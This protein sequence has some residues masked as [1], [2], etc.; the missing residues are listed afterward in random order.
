M[1]TP[2]VTSR[3][4]AGVTTVA[5]IGSLCAAYGRPAN[6]SGVTAS[7]PSGRIL[8]RGLLSPRVVSTS[9]GLYV[10]SQVSPLGGFPFS[11]LARVNS[12][13][14]RI[15][16]T[17]RLGAAFDQAV[18][19]GGSLYVGVSTPSSKPGEA[20]L[21]LNARTLEVTRRWSDLGEGGSLA[22]AGGG[23]WVTG[24]DRLLRL[25]L[26]EGN[27][28]AS[29][30]LPGADRSDV[31]SNAAG[32]ILFVGEAD[33]GR[34]ALERRDPETGTLLAS[35]SPMIGVTAPAVA[36]VVG[37]GVW[38]SEATGMM[39]YVQR[40]DAATLTP[41]PGTGTE[42]SNGISASVADGL[43]WVSQIDGGP[44]TNFCGNPSDGVALSPL[45]LPP[46][47]GL[48]A[49]G[50]H[51]IYYVTATTTAGAPLL[52][53]DVHEETIPAACRVG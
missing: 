3:L 10:A 20:L 43:L 4:L 29:V 35:Y 2:V 8:L 6:P 41:E 17:R 47:A 48:Q 5:V 36:E 16:A 25:S 15:A 26:P 14:G 40:F 1:G 45:N 9:A 53:S 22:L 27:V 52:H 42:G 31:A 49:I 21:R 7:S 30:A 50:P 33:E 44:T 37:Q 38:V 11:E 12:T 18:V 28:I 46:S 34:G 32:T 19:T 51:D 23:L 24:Q 13:T 39:G